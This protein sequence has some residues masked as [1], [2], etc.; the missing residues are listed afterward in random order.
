MSTH[1]VS[2]H[3]S[4]TR[5]LK[6]DRIFKR[7][8]TNKKQCKWWVL[9][10]NRC[11]T[12]CCQQSK[13]TA[14]IFALSYICCYWL[15][16]ATTLLKE[17]PYVFS[18]LRSTLSTKVLVGV[19][20]HHLKSIRVKNVWE[21]LPPMERLSKQCQECIWKLEAKPWLCWYDPGLWGWPTD[22]G[23]QSNTCCIKSVLPNNSSEKQTY[24]SFDLHE[25]S[26]VRYFDCPGRFSLLW[27]SKCLP[28]RSGHFSC[29]C[30][31]ATAKRLTR[32]HGP[33]WNKRRCFALSIKRYQLDKPIK[34]RKQTSINK[35]VQQKWQK[36]SSIRDNWTYIW[37]SVGTRPSS[38]IHDG[39]KPKYD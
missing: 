28:R 37:R 22:W 19:R 23:S 18:S 7:W 30:R 35:Q 26:E 4:V 29:N 16:R 31:R 8:Q 15:L 33:K 17:L 12:R 32:L 20:G 3:E 36:C 24:S 9:L 25:R 2:T 34:L 10:T 1:V 6:D 5:H 11:K 39:D 38:Q 21:A 27:Q 13:I 14:A